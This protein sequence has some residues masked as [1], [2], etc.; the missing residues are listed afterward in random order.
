MAISWSY[1]YKINSDMT[2]DIQHTKRLKFKKKGTIKWHMPS[3]LPNMCALRKYNK[4]L[5]LHENQ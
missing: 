2:N 3:A 5:E 1:G 4:I